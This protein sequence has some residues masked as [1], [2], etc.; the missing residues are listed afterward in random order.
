MTTAICIALL[1]LL[2]GSLACFWMQER[3]EEAEEQA[4]EEW[5]ASLAPEGWD[6]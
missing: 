2:L 4:F 1:V 3:A 5:L 6:R